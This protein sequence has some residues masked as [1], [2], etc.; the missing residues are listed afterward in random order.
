MS[1]F[2]WVQELLIPCRHDLVGSPRYSAAAH[3]HQV[4]FGIFYQAGWS[5]VCSPLELWVLHHPTLGCADSSSTPSPSISPSA[6]TVSGENPLIPFIMIFYDIL[7]SCIYIC[8]RR[9]YGAKQPEI[10]KTSSTSS[11]HWC[12]AW[13][14]T[15]GGKLALRAA[16]AGGRRQWPYGV[17]KYNV[18][19]IW[20][21]CI[22]GLFTTLYFLLKLYGICFTS[23]SSPS[24]WPPFFSIS[25]LLRI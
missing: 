16:L 11:L 23:S 8:L 15:F 2:L 9:S 14:D 4:S 1:Q 20:P 5:L 24:S 7:W 10:Y 6:P 12:G 19:V 25:M 22:F 17:W 18:M 21:H 13:G 3:R